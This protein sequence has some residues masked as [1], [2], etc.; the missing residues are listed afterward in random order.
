VR[1]ELKA[2]E[3]DKWLKEASVAVAEATRR[4]WKAYRGG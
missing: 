1:E 3:G 4:D 2:R